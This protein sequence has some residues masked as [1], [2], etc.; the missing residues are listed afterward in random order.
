MGM[1]FTISA[2]P[3]QR[4]H[5]QV[6]VPRDSWAYFI[7]SDSRLPQPGGPG[8]RIYIP[9]EQGGPVK[10]LDTGFPFRRLLRLAGLRWRYSIPPSTRTLTQPNQSQCQSYF[11]TG[12]LPPVSSSWRQA[13]WDPRPVIFFYL[14]TWGDSSYVTS[15]LTRRLTQANYQSRHRPHRKR[16]F[17]YCVQSLPGKQRVPSNS[18]CTVSCL[19]SCYLAMGLYM[20]YQME[21]C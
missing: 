20:M 5:S 14:N 10:P 8:P 16:L 17:H 13:P 12:G 18:R 2:G 9:Q 11:T 7:A 21:S 19:H 15:S 6:R 1:S 4:S 3:R